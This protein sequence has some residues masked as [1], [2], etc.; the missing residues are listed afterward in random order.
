MSAT[1]SDGKVGIFNYTLTGDDGK[2]IDSSTGK[3]PMV[4]MHGAQNIVPGLEKHLVGKAAGDV[5]DVAV[6]PE[7]GYGEAAGAE[8]QMVPRK[9]FPRDANLFKGMGL[10][11]KDDDGKPFVIYVTDVRG[12]RVYV[13]TDHPLAGKTLH[14]HVEIVSVRDATA[15][16]VAH[17][18]AHGIDGHAHHH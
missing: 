7:E 12:S 4:Y 17:G 13:T 2:V 5:I 6:P 9:D 14:F 16:E 10:R 8:P 15:D 1:L 3:S 11:A 18:H